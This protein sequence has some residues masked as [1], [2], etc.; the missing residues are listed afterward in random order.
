MIWVTGVAG[1]L[2]LLEAQA[3]SREK[4][5]AQK[6]TS[7]VFLGPESRSDARMGFNSVKEEKSSFQSAPFRQ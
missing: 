2:G 3:V 1:G 7:S 4:A 6:K 5:V